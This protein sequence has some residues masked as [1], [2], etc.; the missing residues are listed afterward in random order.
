MLIL[1]FTS[2][3]L[4]PF[5][6]FFPL[7]GRYIIYFRFLERLYKKREKTEKRK[8]REK[9]VRAPPR[10]ACLIDYIRRINRVVLLFL[11][12]PPQKHLQADAQDLIG[13]ILHKFHI[14]HHRH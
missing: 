8:K 3:S 6:P 4:F 5:F 13:S 7:F 12:R 1:G 9:R 2:F 10:G 14:A 11:F